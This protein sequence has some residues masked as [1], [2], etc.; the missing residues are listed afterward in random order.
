MNLWSRL[1]NPNKCFF[2]P[3]FDNFYKRN[4]FWKSKSNKFW[5][6]K[7]CASCVI[8]NWYKHKYR[9]VQE[10]R[11]FAEY[12]QQDAKFHSFFISVRRSTCFRRFFRQSPGAQ[13]CTYSVRYL[14]DQYLTQY[15]QFWAPDNGRKTRLK[16]VDHLKEKKKLWNVASSASTSSPFSAAGD[17]S[18]VRAWSSDRNKFQKFE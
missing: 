7:I 14:S 1:I 9:W 13:N 5:N 4:V 2:L 10:G 3:R 18:R 8:T 11:K 15:V 6:S 16:H 17:C 12:N